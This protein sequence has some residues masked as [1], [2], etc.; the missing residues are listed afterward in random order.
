MG[1]VNAN[2]M[3]ALTIIHVIG[4]ALGVG[5]ATASDA[6]FIRSVRNRTISSE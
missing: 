2:W 4:A 5:G 6:L 3:L 1:D